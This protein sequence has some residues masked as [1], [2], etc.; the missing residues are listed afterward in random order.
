MK[1]TGKK[2]LS[3]MLAAAMTFSVMASTAVSSVSAQNA[4]SGFAD[5]LEAQYT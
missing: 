3:A 1:N 2:I 5:S 4:G